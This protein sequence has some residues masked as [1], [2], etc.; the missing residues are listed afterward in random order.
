MTRPWLGVV[1]DDVTGACDLADAVCDEGASAIVRFGVP[2]EAPAGCDCAVV[3][4]KS[5]TAPVSVAVAQSAAAGRRLL[6]AGC[7]VLYQKYCSTFD[8]ADRGNIGPV[9]DALRAV[10][11]ESGPAPVLGLG[12]PATPRSGRTVYQGH[13]FVG[14]RLL[15]ES[16]MRDH[17]LTPM[18]DADLVAVLSRQ[19]ADRVGSVPWATVRAGT[20]EV[21]AAVEAAR[22]DGVGHLLADALDEADLDTL[23]R[24]VRAL[25][26]LPGGAVLT[27]GAVPP[28]GA[29]L[30]SGAA[31]LAAALVRTAPGAGDAERAR[32][33]PDLPAGRRLILSGSCSQRTRE[34]VAAF[35][36]TR[37]D[38]SP[39]DLARDPGGTVRGVLAAAG[40]AFGS[41]DAPVLVSSTAD[42]AALRAAEARL[43]GQR[44]AELL[45]AATAQIAVRAVETLGVRRLLVAG[46]ETS[47][48]VVRALGV[49][50]LR[51][52]PA[53]GPGLSWMVPVPWRPLV[54]LLK[55]GNFGEPELFTTAWEACP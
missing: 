5:R 31:G 16:P 10:L 2:D 41:G 43:G 1:A 42:P 17:P 30:A 48:A 39:F 20:G 46:G 33:V 21:A 35:T 45:E 40:A 26:G 28:G 8:S 36:G 18:R 23:A 34:Q 9:A 27:G 22:R 37:I 54:L 13:L 38:L 29:V 4:L 53:V 3:A 24:A 6:E 47:G 7:R 11:A 55:S 52:G 44:A 14:D 51:V 12:T 19:T 49:T 15:S 50:A 32:A 25:S